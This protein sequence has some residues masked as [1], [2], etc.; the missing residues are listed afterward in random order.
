MKFNEGII[1][2]HKNTTFKLRA[3]IVESQHL[4]MSKL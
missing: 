3:P 2:Q 4:V 1:K